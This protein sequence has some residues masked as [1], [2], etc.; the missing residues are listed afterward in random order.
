MQVYLP[1]T[2]S[3][4]SVGING[5]DPTINL[6]FRRGLYNCRLTIWFIMAYLLKKC[7][8]WSIWLSNFDCSCLYIY[9]HAAR[10]TKR[11]WVIT[12]L[13]SRC[14]LHRVRLDQIN[15]RATVKWDGG[16]TGEISSQLWLDFNGR[17]GGYW[18]KQGNIVRYTEILP[19]FKMLIKNADG[20][21]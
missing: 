17:T 14:T 11:S 2:I 8:S 13:R 12:L 6:Q 3:Q 16:F 18:K 10:T 7:Q 15:A 1:L 9:I 5:V 21:P 20:K 4:I 19:F